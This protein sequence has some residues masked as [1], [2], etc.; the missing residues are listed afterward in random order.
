M[1]AIAAILSRSRASL[2]N[3][4]PSQYVVPEKCAP[5]L[6]DKSDDFPWDE[7]A[8]LP[9]TKSSGSGIVQTVRRTREGVVDLEAT[10]LNYRGEYLIGQQLVKTD[11][12]AAFEIELEVPAVLTGGERVCAFIKTRHSQQSLDRVEGSIQTDSSERKMFVGNV[13]LFRESTNGEG[14]SFRVMPL[15]MVLRSRQWAHA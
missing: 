4:T 3:P 14:N 5:I 15:N 2:P 1:N 11:G 7:N 6:T 12:K 8:R 10:R 13:L 9:I